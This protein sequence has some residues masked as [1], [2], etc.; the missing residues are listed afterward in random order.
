[1]LAEIGVFQFKCKK[2]SKLEQ[3]VRLLNY[4]PQLMFQVD[5]HQ[6][7]HV[8]MSPCGAMTSY[9]ALQQNKIKTNPKQL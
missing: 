9:F 8:Y 3:A 2:R 4:R 5:V 1:M 7:I 6:D